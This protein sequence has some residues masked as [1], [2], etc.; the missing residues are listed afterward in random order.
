[1]LLRAARQEVTVQEVVPMELRVQPGM[2]AVLSK[3]RSR[4]A[5]LNRGPADY[6]MTQPCVRVCVRACVRA[7]P[8]DGTQTRCL[9]WRGM[10]HNEVHAWQSR[11]SKA[12]FTVGARAWREAFSAFVRH[13]VASLRQQATGVTL[14]PST[15]ASIASS[16]GIHVVVIPRQ[17]RKARHRSSGL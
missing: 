1:M 3:S 6:E 11:A 4:R 12:I 16:S 8:S 10:R 2:A 17:K 15:V 13:G 7:R 14:Q 9:L 5:D